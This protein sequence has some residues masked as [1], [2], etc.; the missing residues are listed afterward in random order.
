M[1]SEDLYNVKILRNYL[2]YL[3]EKL[4][5]DDARI[6]GVLAA[7]GIERS[8]LDSDDNWFDQ[9]LADRFYEEIVA[10]T[11]DPEI[12]YKVGAFAVRENARGVGGRIV[13]GWLSPAAAFKNIETFARAYSRGSVYEAVS[14][15][16]DRA[17]IRSTPV[18]GC[19][20]KPYQC[21][22]RI[23]MLESIPSFFGRTGL[24][25]SH[26]VCLH[27]GADYCEYV[28]S[29]REPRFHAL[30]VSA[31]AA[32]LG[33]GLVA[34][35]FGWHDAVWGAAFAGAV[36][37]SLMNLLHAE[38][39]R[40]AITEQNLGLEESVRIM[41]RRSQEQI[42]LHNVVKRTSEMMPI[43]ELCEVAVKLICEKMGYDRA[44]IALVDAQ[45]GVLRFRAH[46]GY[47]QLLGDLSSVPEFR[48]RPDNEEGILIRVVNENRPI[49]EA[50]M[51]RAMASY[52]E[53]T[54]AFLRRL[55]TRA[56]VAVPIAFEGE[57]QGVLT[58]ENS[59][60]D[61]PL[62]AND[63]DLLASLGSNLAVAM[64]NARHF[65]QVKESLQ[66]TRRLEREQREAREQFQRYVPTDIVSAQHERK[67]LG[68]HLENRELAV[69]FV[70]I[71][72]FTTMSEQMPPEQVAELLNVYIEV[73]NEVVTERGGK[74]NKV[75]GDGL[76]IYFDTDSDQ[77]I[78]TG[79]AIL[80]SVATINRRLG[81]KGYGPIAIGIGAH[82]GICTIG[83]IGYDRRR[84]YTIIGDTVNTAA[85][86]ES[87]TRMW[88]PNVFCF[89]SSLAHEIEP[90]ACIPRGALALKGKEG[91]MDIFELKRDWESE[92]P[93]RLSLSVQRN[94]T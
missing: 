81:E 32:A 22:N 57:V 84:D 68:T 65:E 34:W 49:L 39:T 77:T 74:I 36:A 41:T 66:T 11:R 94:R 29:W 89:S 2:L 17:L 60:L 23:G 47:E 6:D 63:R 3:R 87:L 37:Y 70:D 45:R 9:N 93:N 44:A 8:F 46:S 58:V 35:L 54:Q 55:G 71:V 78:P 88:G 91:T 72:N 18:E 56:L 75:I 4:N 28:F 12:A 10:L 61:K 7:C 76:L 73:V 31:G 64:S 16:R 90:E 83:S 62:T 13:Q 59:S 43:D 79:Q 19:E 50:D 53:R 25:L 48:I 51:A 38:N 42:L 21:R 80:R 24:E 30:Y 5:W 26:P 69:M 92:A 27:Q 14:V 86:V 52:S 33:G 20:E 82:R 40:K 67:T 15:S 1:K 85:R